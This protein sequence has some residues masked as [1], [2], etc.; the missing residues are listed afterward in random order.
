MKYTPF[1]IDVVSTI[2]GTDIKMPFI[3][4]QPA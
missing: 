4:V 3:V 2:F 1:V